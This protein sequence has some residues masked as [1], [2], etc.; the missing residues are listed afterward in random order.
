MTSAAAGQ[1]HFVVLSDRTEPFA[2]NAAALCAAALAAGA[3]HAIHYDADR[4]EEE[5]FW[6]A[7]PHIPRD[8]PRLG[9]GAW[10]PFVMRRMLEAVAPEDV[11][12]LHDAGSHA[13]DKM[14]AFPAGLRH[15]A[16]LCAATPQGMIHGSALTATAQEDLTKQDCLILM[17]ANVPGLRRAPFVSASMLAYRP[18][19]SALAFLDEWQEACADVRLVSDQPD[20]HGAPNLAMRRH[21]Q[22]EAIASILVH[23]HAIPHF[24]L[25][26]AAPDLAEM[27]R[28]R[29][30][31]LDHPEAHVT[32]ILWALSQLQAG[33]GDLASALRHV[34]Q[35]LP[36]RMVDSRSNKAALDDELRRAGAGRPVRIVEAHLRH[37]VGGNRILSALLHALKERP[38]LRDDFWQAAA[39][40]ASWLLS[41]QAILGIPSD[42]D[43]VKALIGKAILQAL[44]DM[45]QL[46][47]E[48]LGASI[49]ARLDLS[50]REVFRAARGA[51]RSPE[52]NEAMAE[53]TARIRAQGFPDE[54]LV[55]RGDLDEYTDR[56]RR[57]LM[58]WL[59]LD[60]L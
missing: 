60:H 27:L 48:L 15:L 16:D 49:W 57:L 13:P 26:H 53:F 21:A 20:R 31:Q 39:A 19:P 55:A 17:E 11:V 50:A 24:D 25:H 51:Y 58:D 5:G 52:G 40:R 14:P 33:A 12:I 30:R 10:R 44:D 36:A 9:F 34:P 4:L 28:K 43:D 42:L 54:D 32:S 29:R 3:D 6:Q 56:I 8:A 7:H 37:V 1:I 35:A 23:R 18:G 46:G 22:E 47:D 45:P 59:L 41:E 2:S 38:E